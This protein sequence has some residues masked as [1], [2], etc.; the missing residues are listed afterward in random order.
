MIASAALAT[1]AATI[2]DAARVAR[3]SGESGDAE[4]KIVSGV[5]VVNY[6]L[7]FAQNDGVRNMGADAVLDWVVMF[8]KDATEKDLTDFCGGAAQKGACRVM[9]DAEG[10]L[11][12]ATALLT[13]KQL[14]KMLETPSA[15][16]YVE[17]DLPVYVIP[18]EPELNV[19][20]SV[21]VWGHDTINLDQA[22]STGAGVH[23]YV[24]D[25]G[26]RTTHQDFGGRAIPTLDTTGWGQAVECNGDVSCAGDTNSHGTHCAGTVAGNKYGAAKKA[27]IHAMKVCCGAG[28]NTLAGMDWISRKAQY[29]A[30]MSMSL[31]SWGNSMSAKSAVDQLTGK[32]VTVVV[33]AGNNNDDAC[34]KTY[35]FIDSAIAVGSTTSRDARSSFSN[36]GTCVSIW[37]PGSSIVSASKADD[38]SSSVKSGTSMATP[39]VAGVAALLSEEFPNYTPK[40]ILG[41]LVRRSKKDVL[42][43]LKSTDVNYLLS[44]V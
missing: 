9:G 11:P 30:V 19:A 20:S 16:E 44:A 17:P 29:P 7:R 4:V 21:P 2:V 14:A 37:A 39:L 5:P 23:V 35:A 15:V 25:T 22:T 18:E 10:G 1:L 42:T 8:K 24:M 33:S 34:K 36:Y 38:V 6:H 13:E 28:T 40:Q 43:G 41:E 31:G 27:T 12:F 26:V 32:G 3:H